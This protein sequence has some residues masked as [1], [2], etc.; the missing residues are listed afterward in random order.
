MSINIDRTLLK[1][2]NNNFR[3]PADLRVSGGFGAQHHEGVARPVATSAAQERQQVANILHHF[4]TLGWAHAGYDF[5]IGTRGTVFQIHERPAQT[6]GVGNHNHTIG[7]NVSIVGL[8]RNITTA[9]RQSL[10]RLWPHLVRTEGIKVADIRGHNQFSGHASNACPDMNMAN[11][12]RDVQAELDKGSTPAPGA[13]THTVRA[14]ETLSS[15]AQLY[16]TTVAELQRLNNISNPNLIFVGQVLILPSGSGGSSTIS[17]GSRVRVNANARTWATGE[18][19]PSWVLGQ[20]YTVQQIRN[21]NNELLLS[22]VMSWIRRA[23]VT[24]V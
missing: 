15:I 23:D 5:I 2:T 9:T 8:G 16:G 11:L 18:S 17:V 6:N 19:I 1:G 21:N 14:G 4:N 24:V 3:R 22:G 10:V 7:R 20:T 12:R 13:N